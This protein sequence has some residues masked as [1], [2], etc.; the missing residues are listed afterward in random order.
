MN[1][2]KKTSNHK[3]RW[4]LDISWKE[5][6]L[7]KEVLEGNIWYPTGKYYLVC[8]TKYWLFGS[9]HYFNKGYNCSFSI[10]FLHLHWR[11]DFCMKCFKS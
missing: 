1:I 11:S 5:I 2:R 8:L 9:R 4:S 7:R 10:G 6:E 3:Y